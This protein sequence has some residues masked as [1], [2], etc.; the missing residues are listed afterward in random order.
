MQRVLEDNMPIVDVDGSYLHRKVQKSNPALT[1][2]LPIPLLPLTGWQVV[3]SANY[4]EMANKVPQVMPGKC[5][6][7]TQL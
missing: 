2:Q 5:Y 1:K 3:N 4:K 7:C 6:I